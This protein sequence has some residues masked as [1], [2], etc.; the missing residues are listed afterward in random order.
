LTRRSQA[1]G[2]VLILACLGAV[3]PATAHEFALESV[4]N[5]FVRLDGDRA[6]LVVRVPLHLLGSTAFPAN[7]RRE[8]ELDRAAP[9]AER[10]LALIGRHLHLREDGAPLTSATAVGRLALPS[11]RSFASWEDAVAHVASPVAPGTVIYLEQGF[12]DAHVTY[13]IRSARADFTIRTT[14][15]AGLGDHVKLVVRF[16]PLEG[17]ARTYQLTSRSGWVAL[18]PRWHRA[19]WVFVK[20]GVH[21]ILSGVDHLLFLLCLA[22][23]FRRLWSLVPVITAFTAAHSVTL[24]GSALGLAPAGAWFPP[25]VEALIAASIVYMA[26]EN[27]VA[28]D[29]RRRWLITGAFGLVHGFGFS[30]A[31][32]EE[33]QFAGSHLLVSLLA[34]N[35]GV[36]LGQLAVLLIA[37][38]ALVLLFRP[39]PMAPMARWGVVI[40]SAL[41]AHTGWHWMV[42]RAEA[43]R[44]VGWPELDLAGLGTLARW[45]FIALLLGGL[46]WWG[47]RAKGRGALTPRVLARWLR[48]ALL[49]TSGSSK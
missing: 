9:A 30:F 31:L 20:A 49:R 39:A 35:V 29:L 45:L 28:A 37:L 21:H 27:I 19:A 38:P 16:L 32:R 3:G 41:L 36:E 44:R 34:F 26:L 47:T 5:A 2:R 17:A 24:I 11:D 46:A 42:D 22:I 15:A 23:P 14:L 8:L 4:L 12:F 13:P 1:V 43:L 18:D 48:V 7:T 25:L 40:L 10:A 33:L 6:H